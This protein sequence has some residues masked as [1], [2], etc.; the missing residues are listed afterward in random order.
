MVGDQT[1]RNFG[2]PR[3]GPITP[4]SEFFQR[5]LRPNGEAI[6]CMWQHSNYLESKRCLLIL[7]THRGETRIRR[8][9]AGPAEA[10]FV[11]PP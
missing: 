8:R 6:N 4:R 3:A 5:D 2:G 9:V 1:F 11:E 7:S 10:A